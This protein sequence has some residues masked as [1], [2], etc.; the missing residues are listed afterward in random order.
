M[1]VHGQAGCCACRKG[2]LL[3]VLCFPCSRLWHEAWCPLL[4]GMARMCCDVRRSIRQA[5]ITYL[6]RALLSH[7]LHYLSANHWE[8]CFLEVLGVATCPQNFPLAV[9]VFS[10]GRC[11]SQ[12][13]AD[14]WRESHPVTWP[15]WRRFVCVRLTCYARCTFARGTRAHTHS[16]LFAGVP[17]APAL[18][19]PAPRVHCTVAGR[20]GLHGEAH[21]LGV[22]RL[23]GMCSC[24]RGKCLHALH[25][26]QCEAVPESLKNLLLVMSTQ[27]VFVVP[28]AADGHTSFSD[29]EVSVYTQRHTHTSTHTQ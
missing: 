19:G 29:A 18:P 2:T 6:Q 16:F 14:C 3:D 10:C 11:S 17:P 24:C 1:C 8:A 26:R 20:A 9:C 23:P 27:Q 12:C 28:S 5:A 15:A 13:W 7:D 25:A 4:Q 22:L 21:V